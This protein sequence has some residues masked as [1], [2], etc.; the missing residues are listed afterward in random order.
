MAFPNYFLGEALQA[1]TIFACSVTVVLRNISGV[2]AAVLK[3]TS[4]LSQA[5]SNTDKYIEELIAEHPTPA[6]LLLALAK[7]SHSFK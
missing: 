4:S 5:A 3:Q 2:K 6:S 1:I 7:F